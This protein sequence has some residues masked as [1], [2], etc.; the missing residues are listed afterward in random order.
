MR[1]DKVRSRGGRWVGDLGPPP[2]PPWR[3]AKSKRQTRMMRAQIRARA[4]AYCRP[5]NLTID[6]KMPRRTT[7]PVNAMRNYGDAILETESIIACHAVVWSGVHA[8]AQPRRIHDHRWR[9]GRRAR[10]WLTSGSRR[11]Y[12]SYRTRG[13]PSEGGRRPCRPRTYSSRSSREPARPSANLS[14]S[15]IAGLGRGLPDH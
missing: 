5:P 13:R 4:L 10:D 15:S 3:P 12:A 8:D 1:A 6:E 2:I 14:G 11:P 9:R 7:T